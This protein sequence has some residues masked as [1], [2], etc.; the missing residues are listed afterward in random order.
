MI[1]KVELSVPECWEKLSLPQLQYISKLRIMEL[2]EQELATRCF[3]KFS[4]LDMEKKDPSMINGELCYVFRKKGIGRFIL[5]VDRFTDMVSRMD[6]INGE[7][8]LFHNPER[9]NGYTGCHWKLYGL[10]LE[11]YLV[12]DQ[13]YA[14]YIRTNDQRFIV[15]M[16]AVLYRKPEEAFAEGKHI[17]KHARRFRNVPMATKLLIVMW[18]TGLKMWIIKKYPY[19][20]SSDGSAAPQSANDYVMGLISAMNNGDVTHNPQIRAT[21]VHEI[22]FEFNL[23]IERSQKL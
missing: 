19:L 20:F 15:N 13:M 12:A 14:A 8:S 10:S 1:T 3:L 17:E 21:E 16:M 9:V 6:W 5:D 22:F 11:E 23:K 2:S 4:G 7:I 18:Y